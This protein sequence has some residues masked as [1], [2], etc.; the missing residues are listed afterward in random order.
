MDTTMIFAGG[1]LVGIAILAA[2]AYGLNKQNP[3]YEINTIMALGSPVIL[4][5]AGGA[6]FMLS[7]SSGNSNKNTNKNNTANARGRR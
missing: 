4:A 6:N 2:V 3:D 5:I 7:G 1:A